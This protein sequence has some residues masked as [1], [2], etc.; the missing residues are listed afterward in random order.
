MDLGISGRTALIT[1]ASKGIGLACAHS[2]AREG[3]N[4]HLASRTS[5]DLEK[6]QAELSAKY[7]VSVE[8]HPCDLSDGDAARALV[9]SCSDVDILVNNA[10]AIPAGDIHEIEETR[11]REAWD[12]KVFGY[13]N[14]CRAMLE[15]MRKRE[16]GVIINVIGAAGEAPRP[17]YVAGAAGNASIMALTRALG[18]SS[19][20]YGVRVVGINPGL[21]V[22]GRMETLSRTW[23]QQRFGDPD[24]WR[25]TLD[26]TYPPGQPEHVSDMVAFLA[27]DL[28]G[29]TTGTIIT[30]DG[31]S[32]ARGS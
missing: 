2:L 5:A 18:G 1:G 3:C 15:N 7:D 26:Q 14:M 25:E 4:V 12:L 10:G 11:W 6:A 29:N 20:E 31:G 23:A 16:S 30:I 24:R 17:G 21:I 28:S 13:Q 32:S 19:R 27:S 8:I 9:A 22:T